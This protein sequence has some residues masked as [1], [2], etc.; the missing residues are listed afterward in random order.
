MKASDIKEKVKKFEFLKLLKPLWYLVL[1]SFIYNL[2]FIF[3]TFGMDQ[4][5]AYYVQIVLNLVF[6]IPAYFVCTFV[7]GKKHGTLNLKNILYVLILQSFSLCLTSGIVMPLQKITYTN[8][9]STLA[10]SLF[11][12][13]FIIGL[14]PYTLLYWYGL[15]QE[16]AKEGWKA[17]VVYPFTVLKKKYKS[18]LNW[19]CGLLIVIIILD[20]L[21]GGVFSSAG[22][23]NACYILYSLVYTYNPMTNWMMYL[24]IATAA[25]VPLYAAIMTVFVYFLGGFIFG[26]CELNYVL[27]VKRQ[28]DCVEEEAA[29]KEEEQRA[30]K[31]TQTHKKK[32]GTS[33]KA[34]NRNRRRSS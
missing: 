8:V 9:W 14:W 7:W 30:S 32:T 33:K 1:F 3:T 26:L 15:Y 4:S 34:K 24:T 2:I 17:V 21:F 23:F 19:F 28:A 10:L 27:L 16:K 31:R 18:L 11:A 13:I 29:K 25:K 20:T 12:A 6:A 22:G 5:L